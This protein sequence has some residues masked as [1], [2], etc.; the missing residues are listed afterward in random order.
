VILK[1][2]AGKKCRKQTV[3]TISQGDRRRMFIVRLCISW[4][5]TH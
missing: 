3:Y 5:R 2:V 4:S 1:R